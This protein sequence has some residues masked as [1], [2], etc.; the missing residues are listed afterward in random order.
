MALTENEID[1]WIRSIQD[2]QQ[3]TSRKLHTDLDPDEEKKEMKSLALLN[4][5]NI[6]LLKLKQVIKKN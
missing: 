6:N 3:Q 4:T 1:M 2:F 5:L